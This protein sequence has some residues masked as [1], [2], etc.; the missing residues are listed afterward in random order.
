MELPVIF[1]AF[2]NTTEDS[3]GLLD[4]ERKAICD[5]LIPLESEQYFQLYRE[6][7]ADT[8]DI[9]HYLTEFKDRVVLFHYGGHASSESLLLL[10]Q[11]A[12]ADGIAEL[13]AQQ[14]NIKVVFLNGCSTEGQVELLLKLGIPA[15][16]ATSV[17]VN[18]KRAM[19]FA[20]VFYTAMANHFTLQEAFETA[21][22]AAKTK[23]GSEVK[24][25]RGLA[26]REAAKIKNDKLPWGLYISE[27]K[28]EILTWKLPS[29]SHKNIVIEDTIA[30]ATPENIPVNVYLTQTLFE[31]FSP[32]NEYL[33][34]ALFKHEKGQEIVLL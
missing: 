15:I 10:D 23:D 22:A 4:E 2:A 24:I 3:L 11:E 27:N 31:A 21:A 20:T 12:H 9:V 1:L 8:N 28:Q 17:P 19:E 16:I 18:D 14:D 33:E 7:T 29:K 32:Y 5:E 26:H 34:F 25:Y 6:P 13:L 30:V